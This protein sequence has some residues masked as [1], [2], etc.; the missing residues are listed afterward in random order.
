MKNVTRAKLLLLILILAF[1]LRTIGITP[2][3]QQHPDE[4]GV[5]EPASKIA[6]NT[7]F[8]H[9]PDP[10]VEPQPF[11]YS[12]SIFY[13]H[14]LIRS[15]ILMS[16]Y[17]IYKTTGFTFNIPK[18]NFGEPSF[19]QFIADLGPYFLSDIL[20]WA[21]RFPSVIFGTLTVLFV[22][23]TALLLFKKGGLA[24]L[25]ALALAIMPQ[26]VRDSHWA[27]VGIIQTFFFT[28]AFYLSAR[29]WKL[30]DTKNWIM[31]SVIAGFAVSIKYFP[32]PLLP[33]FFFLFLART[34]ITP[35]FLIIIFLSIFVGYFLGM[36]YIFAHIQEMI[37]AFKSQ[38][39]F[40]SPEKVGGEQSFFAHILPLYLH[41][42]H[43]NFFYKIAVGPLL[44]LVGLIGTFYGIKKWG[45]EAVSLLI[46][47]VI[48]LLFI[49]FYL[50]AV[51]E[52]LDIP[53]LPFFA[54]FI[55]IGAWAILQKAQNNKIILAVILSIIFLPAFLDSAQASLACTKTITEFEAHDWIAENIP[56]GITLAFQPNMRLPSK[57]FKFVRS[58]PKEKFLLAE[59]QESGAEYVALHS[60][61]TDR[62]SQW[63][64]DKLFLS[65]YVKNNEFT[66]LVLQEYEQNTRLLKSFVK[67]TMCVNSRIY[68]YKIPPLLNP[69]KNIIQ[70]FN[71]SDQNYFSG[72]K[73]GHLKVPSGTRIEL[74]STS[75]G[76]KLK[77]Q[78]DSDIFSQQLGKGTLPP[79]F[80]GTPFR[81]PFI[82][83]NSEKKYSATMLVKKIYRSLSQLPNGFLRLDFYQSNKEEPI[84]TRIS[85]RLT[86]E[87]NEWQ[88]LLITSYAP[89]NAKFA[90]ISF[91]TSVASEPSEYLIDKAT[92]MGD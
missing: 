22:Y 78:Y 81:S 33:L 31:A 50:E 15:I 57:N 70:Q 67:P 49:T 12:S 16:S 35:S 25:S 21:H 88:K 65:Q 30:P 72:W 7:I 40:Y 47:P 44:S 45:L 43:F 28:L 83:I 24:L 76:T 1:L 74:L 32:L 79:A 6:I 52:T 4:P 48:N 19:E 56:E 18:Q 11:K 29:A 64:D 59:I 17:S 53:A 85:P 82:N 91:Q 37:N 87:N 38:V 92:L 8:H 27:T 77:Y 66:H 86:P 42:Y 13:M 55:G 58:E 5:I 26:H 23:K 36:P 3:F 68:I 54:I 60:G 90:T 2:N 41:G 39:A 61:Y 75:N 63:L 73:L 69:A 62:Y 46:I 80:Y 71:F 9:N 10:N 14:A 89:N 51:Y 20:L 34:K 84:L